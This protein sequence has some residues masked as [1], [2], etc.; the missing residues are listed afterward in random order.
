MK[1]CPY[2]AEEIQDEAIFCKHCRNWLGEK[3]DHLMKGSKL[4]N[5]SVI[6]ADKS[7]NEVLTMIYSDS[8]SLNRSKKSIF[9]KAP[10]LMYK[11]AI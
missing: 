8:T 5:E 1:K 11:W 6:I 2:C 3:A 4:E 9:I 10:L 7:S